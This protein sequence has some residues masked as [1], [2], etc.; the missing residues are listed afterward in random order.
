M[1]SPWVWD[2]RSKRYRNTESGRFISQ[3][4]AI[5]LRDAYTAGKVADAD[6]LSR[7]LVN[8]QVSVQEW[9]LEMRR[10]IKDA[11]VNQYMLARGGRNNMT[12][13]DWGRVG[14][15]IHGQ[16]HYLNGFARDIDQGKL[17]EGQIRTR[18]R[19]YINGSTRAFER[20]K[21]DSLGVPVLD[22]YPGD[23]RTVC[24]TNCQC[25]LDYKEL[26]DHWEITW[27]LGEAEHCPDCQDLSKEWAPLVVQ[28]Q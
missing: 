2:D 27:V 12:Q 9:T 26:E 19:M 13:E 7:R 28:K 24:R 6:R 3:R 17:S 23:G 1:P 11:Y 4:T 25:H 5:K 20:A 14:G 22:Q 18:S 8:R 10:Q 21:S 16:Y 15:L